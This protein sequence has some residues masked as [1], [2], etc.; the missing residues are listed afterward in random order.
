[1]ANFSGELNFFF[2]YIFYELITFLKKGESNFV[3]SKS[4]AL[5]S[6]F[7]VLYSDVSRAQKAGNCELGHHRLSWGNLLVFWFL[8]PERI[9]CSAVQRN[10][11]HDLNI[12]PTEE[13]S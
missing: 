8:Q 11:G 5:V 7:P 6:F 9:L 1:M 13:L 4:A 12:A 2:K 3:F 10:F